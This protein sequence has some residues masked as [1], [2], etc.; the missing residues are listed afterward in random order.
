MSDTQHDQLVTWLKEQGHTP[1][2]IKKILAKVAEYDA[3]TLRE[4]VFDSINSG[5]IDL[6]ALVKEALEAEE[7][8]EGVDTT[9]E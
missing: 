9:R 7:G 5:T 3:R 1:D 4:S 2:E 6:A 8:N